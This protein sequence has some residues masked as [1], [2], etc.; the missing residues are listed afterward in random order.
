MVAIDERN[1]EYLGLARIWRDPTEAKV[2]LVG[3]V[4]QYRTTVVSAALLRR[5]IA[6]AA[7]WGWATFTASTSPANRAI[8]SRMRRLGAE[9]LGQSLQMIRHG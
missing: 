5:A 3:V 8:H 2:G 1:G 7:E 4:T 9:S 6:E